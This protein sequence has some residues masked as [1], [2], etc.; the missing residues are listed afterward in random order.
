VSAA[1]DKVSDTLAHGSVGQGVPPRI[2]VAMRGVSKAY[3]GVKAL[4]DVD[5]DLLAGEVHSLVGENGAG[6]STL[7]KILAGSEQPDGGRISIDGQDVA[8]LTPQLAH[9]LG[10]SMVYQEPDLVL[11]LSV[12]ENI[13]LG[14]EPRGRLGRYD[15]GEADRRSAS[16]LSD[17]GAPTTPGAKVRNLNPATRQL[18]QIAKGISANAQVLILDEPGAVLNDYELAH[19]FSL[20]RTL[21]GRGCGIV[22]ISHRLDE[23]QQVADRVTVLRDGEVVSTR[24]RAAVTREGMIADMV[25]RE[26][27]DVAPRVRGGPGEVVL[28]ARSITVRGRI[29]DVSV[30]VRRGEI[31]GLAG[32]AGA[33]RSS[34]LKAVS[35]LLPVEAGIVI[36]DGQDATRWRSVRRFEQGIG[37]IPEGRRQ[38]GIFGGRSI[39][40]NAMVRLLGT[41]PF[42]RVRWDA[43]RKRVSEVTSSLDVKAPSIATIIDTLSGGNQQKVIVGRWLASTGVRVLLLDEPTA[44][45]DVAAKTELHRLVTDLAAGGLGVL[46]A[47]S[48]LVELLSLCDRIVVLAAGRATGELDASMATQE[49]I[50]ALAVPAIADVG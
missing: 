13:V 12:R 14:R 20:M 33:G 10:I 34:L 42:G 25:G 7:M 41:S 9:H 27:A 24:A 15:R 19:L 22:H 39:L 17:V 3:P 37:Y 5:F 40:D 18:V 48:D 49:A 11:D 30:S 28:D 50:M 45:V 46:I 26:V 29:Q 32:L 16:A 35:G 2:L 31:V 43:A 36:L 8:G 4:R 38:F 23:V 21:A 44:G 1:A 47:S 6:K